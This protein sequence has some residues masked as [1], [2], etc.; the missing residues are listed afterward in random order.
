[1]WNSKNHGSRPIPVAVTI[2]AAHAVLKINRRELN[3]YDT[4]T[5]MM[6][7]CSLASLMQEGKSVSERQILLGYL[8][9]APC[10]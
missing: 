3:P 10:L 4:S 9:L 7:L 5:L 8:E 6:L 1:M 2:K